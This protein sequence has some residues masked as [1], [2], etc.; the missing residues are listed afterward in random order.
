[1]FYN[2]NFAVTGH[3]WGLIFLMY[4]SANLTIY[5]RCFL[6]IYIPDLIRREFKEYR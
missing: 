2:K 4:D 3:H 5:F 1:M 6:S